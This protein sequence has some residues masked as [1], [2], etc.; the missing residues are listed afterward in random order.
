[1]PSTYTTSLRLTLPATGELAGTWGTTVNAGVTS[2]AE[3]AIAGT[4]AVTM[5]DAD[6]TLTAVNGSAD[7]SRNMFVTL[8]GTLTAARNVICPPVSKLYFVTNNTTGG[9]AIT[10]KTLAGTG[11]SVP[12]GQ[13]AVVYCNGTDVLGGL[14]ALDSLSLNGSLTLVG[15]TANTVPY[16]NG[17][18]VVT[19]GAA[20]A[21]DGANLSLGT[22]PSAWS[23]SYKSY[24]LPAGAVWS[25]SPTSLFLTSNAYNNG[26]NYIYKT[27]NA[28]SQYQQGSGVHTW[29]VAASGTAGA[30]FSFTTAMTLNAS[31]NLGLGVTPSAWSVYKAFQLGQRGAV[32]GDSGGGTVGVGANNYWNGTNW[33]Y[34]VT[35]VATQ[36]LQGSG[37]HLWFTAPS[38]TAGNA[39]TFTQAMTLDASGNLGIGTTSP[40]AK[41]H[42]GGAGGSVALR[43]SRDLGTDILDFYQGSGVS[44]I[45]ASLAGNSLAFST[46]G[47]ARMRLDSSGNLGLGIT[48]SAWGSS[49]KAIDIG[50]SNQSTISGNAATTVANGAYFTGTNWIYKTTGVAPSL[51]QQT[52]AGQHLWRVA[53]SG[54]AGNAI[55][56]TQAMTLDVNGVFNVAGALTGTSWAPATYSNGTCITR[57][58]DDNYVTTHFDAA[59]ITIGAGISQKT[60]IAIF[61]QTHANGNYIA[62]RTGNAERMRLDSSGNLGVGTASP[63]S[64]L[65]VSGSFSRGVPVTKTSNFTLTGTENWIIHAGSGA[66]TCT[67]PAASS[68]P[69]REVYFSSQTSSGATNILSSA[70][71]IALL[72]SGGLSSTILD[73]TG[74]G[75]RWV[76]IVSDGTNWVQVMRGS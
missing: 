57:S 15:G 36:Y 14:T 3:A 10:F 5:I 72:T 9:Y 31:G 65:H 68:C 58:G 74:L 25:V 35:G 71:N 33:I 1:M 55:S 20:L 45:D 18:K 13:R 32:F 27:S 46:G 23:A 16:L 49:D 22:A 39:I 64:T 48:P 38:G 40:G 30:S 53:P 28:A 69:G 4:A 12:N 54:T 52:Y 56:F 51:Y 70:T 59:S 76:T 21:F 63:T 50:G 34:G 62:F 29:S 2:L 61:G 8:T 26:T 47:T 73:Y 19:T 6:Y 11:I 41:L 7:Q 24:E 67:L 37:S 44:Y 60:G 42:I 66:I 43:I 75:F 17:S